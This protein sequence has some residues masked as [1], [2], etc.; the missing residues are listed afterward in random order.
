MFTNQLYAIED[1][2]RPKNFDFSNPE[3][4]IGKLSFSYGGKIDHFKSENL[5]IVPEYLPTYFNVHNKNGKIFISFV[6][7]DSGGGSWYDREFKYN[8]ENDEY[9][10]T[11]YHYGG[12][13]QLMK[14]KFEKDRD[15]IICFTWGGGIGGDDEDWTY[16]SD[17]IYLMNNYEP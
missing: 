6:Y 14:F 15:K 7:I 12:W 8:A 1:H 16:V 17:L 2:W 4:M 10:F 11:I 13:K 3:K 9:I 5:K